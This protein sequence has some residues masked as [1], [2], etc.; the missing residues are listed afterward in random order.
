MAHTDYPE[1]AKKLVSHVVNRAT[2]E[3]G[4]HTLF[5]PAVT[6][7]EDFYV[8]WFAKTLGNWKALVSTDLVD[9]HYFEV[10]HNG[11]AQETYVD[12]YVKGTNHVV[13]DET[14]TELING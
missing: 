11:N 3:G 14:L 8:V 4:D 5:T 13:S 1:Q 10:T 9:G 12:W 6:V 2:D 7:P